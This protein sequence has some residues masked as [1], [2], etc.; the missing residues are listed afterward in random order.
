MNPKTQIIFILSLVYLISAVAAFAYVDYK[1]DTL[2][3]V[4]EDQVSVVANRFAQEK[5][6]SELNE[7]ILQTKEERDVLEEF[8]LS[9]SDTVTFLADIESIGAQQGVFLSTNSLQVIENKNSNDVLQIKFLIEGSEEQ[10]LHML[11]IFEA[12]PYD[13]EIE[14][15][16]LNKGEKTTLNVT[17]NITLY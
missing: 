7:L 15:I 6:Y 3:K 16:S 17:L 10:L 1:V 5:K 9:E 14:S 11:D 13:N 8:V 12:L 2:G 4:L